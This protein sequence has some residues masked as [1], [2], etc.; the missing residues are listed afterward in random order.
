VRDVHRPD[1]HRRSRDHA[2]VHQLHAA[3]PVGLDLKPRD[4]TAHDLHPASLQ[5]LDLAWAR[6]RDVREEGH[7]V[8]PLPHEQRMLDRARVGAQDS[9]GL[10]PH[11]PPVAIRAV[12]EIPAPPLSNARDL[13][14]LVAGAGRHQDAPRFQHLTPGQANEKAGLDPHDLILDQLH[15]VA[16]N[17]DAARDQQLGRRHPI[18]GQEPMHVGRWGIARRSCI[19]D[20]DSA[21]RPAQDESRAQAGRST[22][23]HHDVVARRLYRRQLSDSIQCLSLV[24]ASPGSP[25]YVH[26]AR[27]RCGNGRPVDHHDDDLHLTPADATGRIGS[28]R[29]LSDR[30]SVF[31][32]HHQTPPVVEQ[33]A[34]GAA[35]VSAFARAGGAS[36]PLT[37]GGRSIRSSSSP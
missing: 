2:A 24:R 16:A 17:L 33:A 30:R 9:D 3:Q 19:D 7:V 15:A 12:E 29:T 28:E 23:H 35:A 26:R 13:R 10:V 27:G 5:L 25:H 32:A 34:H 31:T 14:Q 18:A 11:L 1:Q 37:L 8:G 4:L 36:R 22:A 6:F 20:S 21:P